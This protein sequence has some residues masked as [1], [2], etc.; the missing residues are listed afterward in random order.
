MAAL[1]DKKVAHSE[2][3]S[4]CPK[5]QNW[6]S[7]SVLRSGYWR[8]WQLVG[9]MVSNLAALKVPQKA[10]LRVSIGQVVKQSV[11]MLHACTRIMAC[12]EL[13]QQSRFVLHVTRP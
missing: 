13:I 5:G 6:A 2:M 1:G 4:V 11:N 9:W 3:T 10:D 8:G 12:P 7:T